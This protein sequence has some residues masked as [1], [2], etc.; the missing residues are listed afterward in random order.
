MIYERFPNR[1]VRFSLLMY[2]SG[3]QAPFLRRIAVSLIFALD[4]KHLLNEV[5]EKETVLLDLLK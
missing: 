3:G 4:T 1:G 2:I 5:K